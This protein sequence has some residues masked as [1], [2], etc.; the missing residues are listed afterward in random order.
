MKRLALTVLCSLWAFPA[1]A[2][3]PTETVEKGR[4]LVSKMI[5]A[6]G[7]MEALK[8]K[9]DVQYTYTYRSPKGRDVSTERYIFDGELSWAKYQEHGFMAPELS[10]EVIQGWN[11][12]DAWQTVDQA[13]VAN[14]KALSMSRFVRKT[15][16]YWFAMMQK[17]A[18][19]GLTYAY[20]GKRTVDGTEYNIVKVQFDGGV[21]DAQDTY[22]LYLNPQTHLVDQF[23]FTVMAFGMSKPHLMKVEYA[24]FNG[25]KLPVKRKYTGSDWNGAL[26]D[27]PTW[28]HEIMENLSFAN[29]FK[30]SSFDP[31]AG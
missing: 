13:P 8:K 22:V 26:P 19:P 9:R 11:G 5:E 7:S 30:R 15:N 20:D 16:F 12:K 25:V 2:S 28:T 23:L 17:L 29:G 4:A 24:D 14:E 31:P 18:D 6:V 27:N 1:A 10:G 3:S 21:G